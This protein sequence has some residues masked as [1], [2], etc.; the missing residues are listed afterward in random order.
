MVSKTTQA[1]QAK[2]SLGQYFT[3][4]NEL[5][6]I[7]YKFILNN[8]TNILEPSIGQGD[9]V[10][11]VTNKLID[12]TFDMYEIDTKIKLLDNIEKD[13]VIYG[14]FMNQKITKTY[15]TIIG[16][17]PYVRTKKRN[18]Y[19]DFIEKCYNLLDDDGELI[20]IIPSDFFKLT[21]ASK[22]L[23]TM[24]TNGTFTHIYHPHNEK[25]F[26]GA[27]IDVIVF[28]YNK[29]NSIIKK[30]LY[31]DK[32]KY[33]INSDGLITFIDKIETSGTDTDNVMFKDY[34]DIYVGIV[35]GKE[36]VYKNTSLGN[37]EVLNGENKVDKYIYIEK[38]PCEEQKINEYLFEHKKKLLERGMKKFNEKNWFEWGAPRNIKTINKNLGKDC[39]Y[40]YNLT[41]RKN[42]AFVD[43]VR[44]FGGGLI[45]LLPKQECPAQENCA[46]LCSY[47]AGYNMHNIAAPLR[48]CNLNN[49]V[50]YLNSDAFKD[51]FIFSGRFKIGHR[52]IS[53]FYIPNE[54]LH[55]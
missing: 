23:N 15:K 1:K 31:N 20:F 49:I 32:L 51:N 6:E 34:F 55:T 39:I 30:V 11:F 35:N 40:I 54:Y 26:D 5:K 2:Q 17:P 9:L 41:R 18:L 7:V 25:L 44:Y 21:S 16:N 19:I 13:K 14:D 8:P 42:V 50:T 48:E 3:T 53:N 45:M 36:E 52:Q 22:L 43:K 47:L 29:N 12:V 33:I 27:N 37:I 24:M 10:T 4:N 46:R 38:Y 28:R